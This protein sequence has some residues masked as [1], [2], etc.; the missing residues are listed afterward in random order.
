[1]YG[2]DDYLLSD[3]RNILRQQCLE[4][5]YPKFLNELLTQKQFA[6]GDFHLADFYVTNHDAYNVI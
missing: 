4:T 6:S 5:S 3:A 2:A 1:M